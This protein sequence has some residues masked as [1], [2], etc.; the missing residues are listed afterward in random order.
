MVSFVPVTCILGSD[1][2]HVLLGGDYYAGAVI[3]L[4]GTHF[5]TCVIP[6]PVPPVRVGRREVD[7]SVLNGFPDS[8]RFSFACTPRRA[9]GRR[10][11]H[12]CPSRGS[13]CR[14]RFGAGVLHPFSPLALGPQ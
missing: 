14:S 6:A 5:T 13:F 10:L 7:T 11:F 1:R 9:P 8:Q 12:G 2:A 3:A 4:S